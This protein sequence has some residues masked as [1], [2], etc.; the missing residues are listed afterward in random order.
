MQNGAKSKYTLNAKLTPKTPTETL[1][2]RQLLNLCMCNMTSFCL[3]EAMKV[4]YGKIG[5]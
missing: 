5:E 4:E 2:S 1:N 3:S